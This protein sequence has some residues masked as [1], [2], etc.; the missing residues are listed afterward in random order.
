MPF[1]YSRGIL[2]K[3]KWYISVIAKETKENL[4]AK[5]SF[6]ERQ[7]IQR[8]ASSTDNYWGYFWLELSLPAAEDL[9]KMTLF[10]IAEREFAVIEGILRRAA[11]KMAGG[12]AIYQ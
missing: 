1:S 7:E 2:T 5:F 4:D 12:G 11:N 9:E 10:D 6:R 3:W 8:L